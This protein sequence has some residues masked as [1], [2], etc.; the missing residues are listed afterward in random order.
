MSIYVPDVVEADKRRQLEAVGARTWLLVPIMAPERMWGLLIVVLRNRSL[1]IDDDLS[2]LNLLAQQCAIVLENYRLIDELQSYSEQLERKVEERTAALRESEQRYRELNAELE[3][4][5]RDRT[6]QLEVANQELEAFSYSVSHDLRAPLRAMDGFSKALEEDYAEQIDDKGRR[7]LTRIRTASQ[8]MGQLIDD[9][10]E[11]SHLSRSEMRHEKVDLSGLA[12]QI[13]AELKEQYPEREVE[14]E[15]ADGLVVTGDPRLLRVALSNLLG[16]AW[17]YTGKQPQPLIR[18][19][20]TE[21]EGQCTYFVRDNGAG[22]DMAYADKLFGVF[23]R[24]HGANEFPG[25]GIGLATVQRIVNRH[26]GQIWAEA[27]VNQG[28]TFYFSL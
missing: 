22:F 4:R 5:V 23:Q 3:Q 11:M 10:L 24:L 17:K 7:Y 15:V 21:H 12:R 6:A 18:L 26:G 2:L 27:A 25:N 16:N 13:A 9:L 14:F 28:A 1:F 20:K 19:G 8:H